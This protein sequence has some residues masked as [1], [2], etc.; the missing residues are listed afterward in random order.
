MITKWRLNR[1]KAVRSAQEF[2]LGPLTILTGANSSGK[3]SI[4]QSMLLICQTLSSKVADRQLVLNGELLRLGEFNDV[5]SQGSMDSQK[6]INIGFDIDFDF[7]RIHYARSISRNSM[8]IGTYYPIIEKGIFSADL[9]FVPDENDD[10]SVGSKFRNLQ[11]CLKEAEFKALISTKHELNPDYFE[12]SAANNL[13]IRKR[14]KEELNQISNDNYTLGDIIFKTV[15]RLL[16]Y[17]ASL[18]PENKIS[19]KRSRFSTFIKIEDRRRLLA[20]G[21]D[22]FLPKTLLYSYPFVIIKCFDLI[23]SLFSYPQSRN[24]TFDDILA[25]KKLDEITA[26]FIETI[27]EM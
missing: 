13:K 5:L 6:E 1:F 20:A 25:R 16:E 14:D 10:R 2:S 24:I 9:S 18:T 23:E 4:I 15:D 22:H 8:Y 27:Q 7:E 21:L 12:W 26:A 11:S 3:S 19:R 17:E